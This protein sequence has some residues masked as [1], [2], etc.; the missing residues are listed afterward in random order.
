MASGSNGIAGARAWMKVEVRKNSGVMYWFTIV[1]STFDTLAPAF[2]CPTFEA[3]LF[4][5]VVDKNEPAQ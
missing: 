3:F 4:A 5:P 2:T 1:P